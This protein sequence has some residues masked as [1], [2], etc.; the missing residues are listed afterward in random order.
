M[1]LLKKCVPE[2]RE[3]QVE[4]VEALAVGKNQQGKQE[5]LIHWRTCL[6][7]KILW[8]Q[9]TSSRSNFLTSNLRTSWFLKKGREE[10]GGGGRSDGSTPRV[11]PGIKNVYVRR[12]NTN[13]PRP[14]Q[15]SDVG[16][17]V[18]YN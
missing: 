9:W 4:P 1:S 3:L 10:K 12:I 13:G 8:K 15:Q 6:P 18:G 17:L 16:T 5:V 14:I 2:E 7:L 11:K